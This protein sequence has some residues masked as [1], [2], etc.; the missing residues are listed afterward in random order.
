MTAYPLAAQNGGRLASNKNN[1]LQLQQ[2]ESI[3]LNCSLINN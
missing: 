2:T 1:S 3:G